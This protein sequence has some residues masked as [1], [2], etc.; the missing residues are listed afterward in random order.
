MYALYRYIQYTLYMYLL[1]RPSLNNLTHNIIQ[2]NSQN[3]IST[4]S[5]YLYLGHV[6]RIF[7][8]GRL[9]CKRRFERLVGFDG[10][11]LKDCRFVRTFFGVRFYSVFEQQ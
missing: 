10:G 6:R 4:I 3:I 2:L 9:S 8:N 7:S 5:L 11:A 1:Y